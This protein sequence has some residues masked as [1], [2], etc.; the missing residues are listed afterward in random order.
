MCVVA[1]CLYMVCRED[2]SPHM[3]IDFSGPLMTHFRCCWDT[4][5]QPRL[6]SLPF[7]LI[8]RTHPPPPTIDAVQINVYVLGHAFLKFK[9]LTGLNLAVIDPS[10]YIHRFAARLELG[11]EQEQTKVRP[12]V[13]IKAMSLRTPFLLTLVHTSPC[14]S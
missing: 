6:A 8:D 10:I 4:H 14:H 9:Q 12:H 13:P 3:L 2:N 7:R 11:S 5:D 1:V